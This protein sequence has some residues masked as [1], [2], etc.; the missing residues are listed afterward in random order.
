LKA[1]DYFEVEIEDD[2]IVFV[3]Q[4]LVSRDELAYWSKETQAD[5]TEALADV[6]AGRVKEFEN[7]DDLLK[8]LNS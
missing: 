7:V 1:G 5:I 6:A 4:K 3:P 2:R 8:D